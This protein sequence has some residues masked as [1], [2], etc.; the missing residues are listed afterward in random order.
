MSV[1]ALPRSRSHRSTGLG[2]AGLALALMSAGALPA[3]ASD[4][5]DAPADDLV[6]VV[7]ARYPAMDPTRDQSALRPAD[8]VAAARSAAP[9]LVEAAAHPWE[10]VTSLSGVVTDVDFVNK[11]VGYAAAELGVVWKTVDGGDTWAQVVNVGFP[12]YFYGVEALS[13]QEVVVSGFDNAAGFVEAAIVWRTL[14]GGET[15]NSDIG[16]DPYWAM[17]VRFADHDHGLINGLIGSTVWH[18]ET[19]GETED[20]WTYE[21]PAEDDGWFAAQFTLLPSLRAYAS[22]ISYCESPDGGITWGCEH[23]VDEVFDGPTA[24]LNRNIGWVG[25]GTIS[26]T[27]E[28]WLHRTTDGGDTWSDR[29]LQTAYPIRQIQAINKHDVWAAG[30]SGGVGGINYSAD[31]GLTWS[32]DLATDTEVNSCSSK[33]V[34]HGDA[35]RIWC[36]GFSSAGGWHSNLYKVTVPRD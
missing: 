6:E 29:V 18:T 34:K 26:P 15:W 16:M 3:G 9:A 11:R 24:F 13:P 17:R 7:S 2:V 21:Q 25:G 35:D 28:G 1:S 27:V 20:E 31:G 36:F 19:G 23:S 10:E 12:I 30:G 4:G 5:V 33:R 14:D 22:G 32:E 8:V